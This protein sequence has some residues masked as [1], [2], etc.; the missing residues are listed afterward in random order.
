VADAALSGLSISNFQPSEAKGSGLVRVATFHDANPAAPASDFTATITWGDG[1]TTT[2]SGTTGGIVSLGGGNFALMASHTYAEEGNVTVSVQVGDVG[3]ASASA[4]R[5]LTVAD[6]RLL[7][8]G[9]ATL[10]PTEGIGIGTA[11]VATFTDANA[12]APATDFTAVVHWGD[13]GTSTVTGGGIV[14]LGGGK[15]AVPAA[16]TYAEAGSY[17]LS[18]QV[19]DVGGASI[20]GSLA[21][22]VADEPLVNLSVKDPH[23]TAGKDTGPFIVATFHDDN[24]L[25]PTSGFTAVVHWGDGT[26]STLTAADFVSLGNGDFAVLADH[27]YNTA[28]TCTLSVLIDDVGGGSVSGSLKISVA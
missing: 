9:V 26:T 24:A 14:S 19:L 22:K 8:L 17:T 27:L 20:S 2:L 25:A 7:S 3:G 15:F 1:G 6:A 10:K 16:Y 12:A 21:T 13:G 5:V 11:T 18:V 23:A 28:G 4:S